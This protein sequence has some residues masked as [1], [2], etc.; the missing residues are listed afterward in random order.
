MLAA[1]VNV[2]TYWGLGVTTAWVFA[3]DLG[4]R[5]M[6]FWYARLLATAVQVS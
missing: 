5:V 6:G 3:F 1:V 2:V 4:L